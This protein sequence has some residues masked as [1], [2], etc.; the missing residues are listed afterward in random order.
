MAK[1]ILNKITTDLTTGQKKDY[2]SAIIHGDPMEL[3]FVISYP[4]IAH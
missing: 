4:V 3:S 2:T 1:L